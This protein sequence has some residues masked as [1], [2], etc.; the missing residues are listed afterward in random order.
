[1]R[2]TIAQAVTF[3][4]LAACLIG[5]MIGAIAS[6]RHSDAVCIPTHNMALCQLS[7]MAGDSDETA[8]AVGNGTAIIGKGR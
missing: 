2:S 6:Q 3:L 7:L 1:M 8:R 4:A 5:W